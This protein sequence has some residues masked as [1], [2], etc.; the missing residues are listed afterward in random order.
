MSYGSHLSRGKETGPIGPD[1]N[2]Q[3]E[4]TIL[5]YY[6]EEASCV[7]RAP[8]R[9]GGVPR[10]RKSIR[11]SPEDSINLCLRAPGYAYVQRVFNAQKLSSRNESHRGIASSIPT[12]LDGS[13]QDRSDWTTV[14][15]NGVMSLHQFLST[16]HVKGNARLRDKIS[17]C[18]PAVLSPPFGMK[19]FHS[20]IAANIIGMQA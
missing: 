8:K 20:S 2:G 1:C 14:I 13:V 17:S 16:K 9:C 3:Y 7:K 6:S 19:A 10:Q 5:S 11:L 12:F 15:D 4:S 18:S